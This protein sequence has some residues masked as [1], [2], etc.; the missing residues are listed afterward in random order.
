M[1][2]LIFAQVFLF[3]IN[4]PISSYLVRLFT[5]HFTL[6]LEFPQ[7]S[8]ASRC[9]CYRTSIPRPFFWPDT[10]CVLYLENAA[11]I[12]QSHFRRL[13]ECRNYLKVKSTVLFLQS[14]VRA[15]LKVKQI[16][17][18]SNICTTKDQHFPCGIYSCS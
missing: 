15:W 3:L 8:W 4:L 16:S 2:N 6:K 17:V 7:S 1:K 13:I 10:S 11:K 18:T 14:V 5:S 9:S 12:I